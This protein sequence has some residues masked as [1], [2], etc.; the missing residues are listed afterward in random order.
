MSSSLVTLLL[1]KLIAGFFYSYQGEG[2][3]SL[4]VF[5]DL[6]VTEASAFQMKPCNDLFL[7]CCK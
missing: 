5:C 2:N 1:S 6:R 3:T 7:L 4:H